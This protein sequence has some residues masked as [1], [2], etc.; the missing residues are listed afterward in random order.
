MAHALAAGLRRH[1]VDLLFGQ[2][3]PAGLLHV[4]PQYGIR[5]IGYRTENAGGAM[6]DGYA[7]ISNRVGVVC[8]QNGPAATLLVPPMAEALK[9]S[10]PI[11][12]I[13]EEVPRCDVERNAFQ[14]Y[15]HVTLFQSCSKWA[16]RLDRAERVD[17]FLDMAMT[18]ATSGRPGPVALMVPRDLFSEVAPARTDRT[19]CLGGFPLD[20]SAPASAQIGRAADMIAKAR[21]PLIIAGGGVH[22][23]GAALEVAAF[24]ALAGI[25]VAT[26]NMGK[27]VV[28]ER[29]PLALGVFGN[30]MGKASAATHLRHYAS[31]ADVVILIGTRTNQNGTDAWQLFSSDAKFI[32]IDIDPVEVGRNYEALRLVG[33]A[34][35][36]LR[37]LLTVLDGVDF[38]HRADAREA[39]A[40][41]TQAARIAQAKALDAIGEGTVGALRP[42]AMMSVLDELIGSDDIVVADASYATN[43]LATYLTAK[44]D[45]ARFLAP[46]GLAGLGWGFPL[47]LGAHLARPE[48]KVVAIVGDGGFGH[49]WSELEAARRMGA[50][51]VVI[52]LNNS[53]LGFQ[54]HGENAFSGVHSHAVD[55][56]EVDHAL[57]AQACGCYGERV[58]DPAEFRAALTRCFAAD[59]PSVLDVT[60]DPLASPPLT[61]LDGRDLTGSRLD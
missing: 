54:C 24:S 20:R 47:A 55:L 28:D 23:S 61:M 44:R 58:S 18:M 25:P 7:R 42:E 27:G 32:H 13:V 60:V 52:V 57:I 43:W 38:S 9:A 5:Q 35:T 4:T 22:L 17:D 40:S 16:R 21:R 46:R 37:D 49:C 8:A 45:G 41:D 31:E 11:L 3:I 26:T 33:D 1:G 50:S 34:Q 48:A 15:D 36:T 29:K 51:V 10:V 59:I 2:S 12:A 56:N 53:I 14:E 19:A 39:I 6:A 30:T